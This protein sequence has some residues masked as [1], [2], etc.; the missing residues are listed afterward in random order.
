METGYDGQQIVGMDRHRHRS[1]LVSMT[2]DGRWL[3]IDRIDKSPEA[4]R[5]AIG[6][7][8]MNLKVVLEATYGGY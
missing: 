2:V 5:T 1:V 7:A 3:W 4:L 8:G 6:R